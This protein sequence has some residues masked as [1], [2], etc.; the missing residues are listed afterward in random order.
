MMHEEHDKIVEED[1]MKFISE[2]N[3][4]YHREYKKEENGKRYLHVTRVVR[5]G[6]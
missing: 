3:K 4:K 2:C 5:G 1:Y 6:R